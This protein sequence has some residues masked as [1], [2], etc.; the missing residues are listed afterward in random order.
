[1]FVVRQSRVELPPRVQRLSRPD[2]EPRRDAHDQRHQVLDHEH[3]E[4][5]AHLRVVHGTR[6]RVRLARL[7]APRLFPLIPKGLLVEITRDHDSG[8]NRVEDAED[9]DAHHQPL[10]LLRFGAVVLHNGPDAEQ[11]HEARQEERDPDEQIDEERRQDESAQRVNAV[12]AH[13]AHAAEHI[14][15]DLTHGE[16]GDGLDGWHRPRC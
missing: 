3:R 7:S 16:D 14:S 8:W 1:M 13:R 2:P 6:H 10:Q 15:I 11:R 12:D 9:A 5:R 4:I